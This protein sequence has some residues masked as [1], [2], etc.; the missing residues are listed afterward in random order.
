MAI[1]FRQF[2]K[3]KSLLEQQFGDL[4]GFQ[5]GLGKDRKF[6]KRMVMILFGRPDDLQ[7]DVKTRRY[8]IPNNI[9][10]DTCPRI[11]HSDLIHAFPA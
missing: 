9:G 10:L 5:V 1:A 8:K 3:K 7:A 11:S 6:A 2:Y 4:F